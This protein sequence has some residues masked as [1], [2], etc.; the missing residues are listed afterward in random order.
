MTG[1]PLSLDVAGR[2]FESRPILLLIGIEREPG[3]ER[4]QAGIGKCAHVLHA[5]L[6]APE[7]VRAVQARDLDPVEVIERALR[8]VEAHASL[9]AFITVCAERA[10]ERARGGVNGR[11]INFTYY[12]DAYDPSK[13]VPLT[14]KLVEQDKIFADFGSLGTAPIIAARGYLN[15]KKV[16]QVLVAS[17]ADYWAKGRMRRFCGERVFR[18]VLIDRDPATRRADPVETMRA[19][20]DQGS[21]LIVFPE[22][23]RNTTDAPLMP[24]KSGLFHL[25]HACPEV[26]LVPVWVAN[27]NRVMPKGEVV[28]IPLLCT[29]TFGAP[30]RFAPGE[31]KAAFLGRARDALLRLAPAH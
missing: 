11:Q 30:L 18:A 27:L 28:P 14:Q 7:I 10:L 29:V 15:K 31:N 12:D 2:L 8:E 3:L 5:E 4:R 13:S 20:L 25:A 21:S 19:A 17:G 22:G 6:S 16:P 24:F 23:T 26:D 9:N 1:Y